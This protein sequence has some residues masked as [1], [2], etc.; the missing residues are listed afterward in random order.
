MQGDQLEANT[1]GRFKLVAPWA[2][3]VVRRWVGATEWVQDHLGGRTGRTRQ[4]TAVCGGQDSWLSGVVDK[5]IFLYMR[6]EE[7]F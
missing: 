6:E 7:I 5:R 2:R 3:A 4:Q 1:E